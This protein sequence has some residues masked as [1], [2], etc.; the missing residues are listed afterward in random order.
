MKEIVLIYVQQPDTSFKKRLSGLHMV[1]TCSMQT[2]MQVHCFLE[3][4]SQI[5]SE[6]LTAANVKYFTLSC[7]S[8]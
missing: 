2:H 7:S 6:S 3:F 1:L 5:V 4:A 8:R